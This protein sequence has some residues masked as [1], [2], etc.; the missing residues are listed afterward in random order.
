MDDLLAAILSLLAEALLEFAGELFVSLIARAIGKIIEGALELGAVATTVAV[1]VLGMGSGQ[2]SLLIFPHPLVHPSRMHGI[3]LLISPLITGLVM[4]QIG[5]LLRNRGK[6]TVAI[7][8]FA[9]GFTFALAM[10]A[11]RFAFAK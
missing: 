1:A 9:Y 10:A 5:R 2:L 11:I 7:E 3:S 4:S 6:E 8:S